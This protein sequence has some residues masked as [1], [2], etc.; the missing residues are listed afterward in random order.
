MEYESPPL[1]RLTGSRWLGQ[2]LILRL[3]SLYKDV[4]NWSMELHH[5]SITFGTI[6]YNTVMVTVGRRALKSKT[7]RDFLWQVVLDT[8]LK[9][10]MV[11]TWGVG[12]ICLADLPLCF[13]ASQLTPCAL[14]KQASIIILC[15]DGIQP[16]KIMQTG[17]FEFDI[18][19]PGSPM[20][21]CEQKR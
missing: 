14:G 13:Q 2:C 16:S 9:M 17:N 8:Y 15:P 4:V 7:I 19:K 5:C 6:L 1:P 12:M 3:H 10:T 21:L 11:L 20:H 18:K